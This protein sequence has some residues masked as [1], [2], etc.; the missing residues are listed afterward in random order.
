MGS[1]RPRLYVV[2]RTGVDPAH[3]ALR[4]GGVVL[5]GES[6][7]QQIVQL[8][9]ADGHQRILCEGGPALFAELAEAGLVDDLFVTLSPRLF[10]RFKGDGRKALTDARDLRGM[11]LQ[12]ASARRHESHLFLRYRKT[13][14]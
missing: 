6:T 7:P 11:P 9:R 10:G 13:K 5:K 14:S 4:E 3:P 1:L 8:I 12:L 2:S